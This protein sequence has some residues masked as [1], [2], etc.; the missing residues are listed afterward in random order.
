MDWDNY[1]FE[2]AAVDAIL[3]QTSS[4]KLRQKALQDNPSWDQ[5]MD[6]GMGQ[7]Q[8]QR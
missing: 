7:E 2:K 1:N 5:L 4:T 3:I 8:G 6:M